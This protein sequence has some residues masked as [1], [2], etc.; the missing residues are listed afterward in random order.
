MNPLAS[1]MLD[2]IAAVLVCGLGDDSFHAREAYSAAAAQCEF[3]QL[4]LYAAR[5]H[6]DI[7]IAKRAERLTADYERGLETILRGGDRWPWLD[8]ALHGGDGPLP[9]PLPAMPL[10]DQN[11]L[12][13]YLKLARDN[14][15][16]Y[17]SAPDYPD[18]RE[19]SMLYARDRFKNGVPFDIVYEQMRRAVPR[20][21]AWLANRRRE[22][23]RRSGV[24]Q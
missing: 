23:L 8:M 17:A 14:T 15:G 24:Q 5:W 6:R 20:E 18:Y 1:P 3:A 21:A 16:H 2:L 11:T 7:E 22:E 4:Y 12:D 10:A 13:R 19:A 9:K